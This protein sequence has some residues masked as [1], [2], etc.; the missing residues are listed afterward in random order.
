[1]PKDKLSPESARILKFGYL[2]LGIVV[3]SVGL[4]F[5]SSSWELPM[6]ARV[7][8]VIMLIAAGLW[9][10]EAVPLFVTSF[11]V[12][13][14]SLTWLSNAIE[15]SGGQVSSVVFPNLSL[16]VRSIEDSLSYIS[17]S[18]SRSKVCPYPCD[19]L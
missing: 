4:F 3:A 17:V 6:P 11:V 19:V 12:L 15:E 16:F 14:L 18:P 7:A 2:C 1:M 10:S 9:V 5:L 8:F 13:I